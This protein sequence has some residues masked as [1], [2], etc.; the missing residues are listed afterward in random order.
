MRILD[1]VADH[2]TRRPRQTL[3]AVLAVTALLSPGLGFQKMRPILEGGLPER[4]RVVREDNLF[5]ERWPERNFYLVGMEAADGIFNRGSLGRL[6]WL[7]DEAAG[8]EGALPNIL[9][10]T[11]WDHVVGS[12]DTIDGRELVPERID[13]EAL[14]EIARIVRDDPLIIGRLLSPDEKL[15][16]VRIAFR[17]DTPPDVI[18]AGL[19]TLREGFDG[20]E[21][22]IIYGRE[23]LNVEVNRAVNYNM[24][25]LLPMAGV[26]LLILLY[27]CFGR[28]QAVWTSMSVLLLIPLN[29]L[30]LMGT[31]RI[32][33]TVLSSTVPVLLIVVGGSYVVH[34]LGR[35]YEEAERSP[36]I[37]AVRTATARTGRPVALALGSTATGFA[38]LGVFEIHSIREFGYLA[39][40]GVVVAGLV[41]LVWL[42]ALL[43]ACCNGAAPESSLGRKRFAAFLDQA[44]RGAVAAAGPSRRTVRM[45][46]AGVGVVALLGLLRLGVGSN[47]SEYFPRQHSIRQALETL[48]ERFDG[49]GFFFADITAPAGS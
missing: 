32:P 2:V 28:W 20:P 46:A 35:V 13:E 14:D 25:I 45:V 7:S 39:A 3:L 47:V 9:S 38:T 4:D 27:L 19:E 48:L 5:N 43:V 41:C 29:F 16:L 34:L 21:R 17:S 1:T 18:H 36:W 11:T 42:P 12:G 8:L 37:E 49:N 40:V 31:L 23:Y 22:L 44:T 26:L 6:R 15:A 33:Q 24:S 30:G 10:L